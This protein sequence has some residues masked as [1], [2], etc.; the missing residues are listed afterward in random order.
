MADRTT[1][2]RILAV[3][4]IGPLVLGLLPSGMALYYQ[5]AQSGITGWLL[6]AMLLAPIRAFVLF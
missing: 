6:D 1:R 2:F 3:I 4:L 5:L